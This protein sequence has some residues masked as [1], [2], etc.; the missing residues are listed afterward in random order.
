VRRIADGGYST[1]LMPDVPQWQPAPGPTLAFA[2]ALANM[3]VGTYAGAQHERAIRW[4]HTIDLQYEETLGRELQTC[5]GCA[6]RAF[7]LGGGFL[8]RWAS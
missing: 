8:R 7:D 5:D 4:P 2:A 3:R 1:L 6:P